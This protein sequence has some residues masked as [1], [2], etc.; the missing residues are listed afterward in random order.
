MRYKRP[1]ARRQMSN[2]VTLL[3]T[4]VILYSLQSQANVL[5]HRESRTGR[6]ANRCA[7]TPP[8]MSSSWQM[9][10]WTC[11]SCYFD[12]RS[13][14]CAGHFASRC[15]STPPLTNSSWPMP[16]WTCSSCCPA[17]LGRAC[18][19]TSSWLH[20]RCAIAIS[21]IQYVLCI[22]FC[23]YHVCLRTLLC[24]CRLSPVNCALADHAC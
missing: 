3:H 20:A 11:S 23:L 9:P 10:W 22:C 12:R 17:A 21:S 16:L 4:A 1:S 8:L 6:C 14:V 18:H 24:V 5:V 19:K 15:A 7:S 2:A 13:N